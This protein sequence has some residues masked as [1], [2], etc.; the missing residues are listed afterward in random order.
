MEFWVTMNDALWITI[1]GALLFA[2]NMF[3]VR[4]YGEMEFIFATLK[5]LL[6]IGMNIMALVVTCGGGPNH[7]ATGFKYWHSP[8]PFVQYLQFPGSLGQFMGF[9]TTFSNAAYAYSGVENISVAAA[10]TRSPRR[11]IPRAAK[12]IFWRVLI[13]YVLSIFMITLLVPSNDLDLLSSTGTAADSPFVIAAT[14]ANIPVVPSMINF[15]VLT[16]A[17][18]SGN[19]TLLGGSRTLFG[20]AQHRHAPAFFKRTNRWGVPYLAV[21]AVGIW[22]ALGYMSLSSSAKMVF[23]WLRDLIAAAA[24]VGWSI[25]CIVYLRFYYALK[26]QNISR[27]ELPWKAPFQ[28]YAAWFSL[29]SFIILLLTGGYTCFISGQ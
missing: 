10:E 6:I 9:W 5:I 28:P 11:N 4:I 21:M 1:F 29:T 12:R 14:R 19:S 15:I 26:K 18:S 25:T 22:V 7:Q 17:W 24:L 2:S 3:L 8:G 20:L 16:S 13:F 23:I 27:N